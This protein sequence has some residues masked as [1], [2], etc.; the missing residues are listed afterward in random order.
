MKNSGGEG[1]KLARPRLEGKLTH[2]QPTRNKLRLI[3][4]TSINNC[5]ILMP[6]R[7]GISKIV[8][9]QFRRDGRHK[10][11]IPNP[12]TKLEHMKLRTV[13]IR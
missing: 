9:N 7:F 3:D 11:R 2:C 10:L 5:Q 1:K 4:Y 8:S 12:F 13:N 6:L